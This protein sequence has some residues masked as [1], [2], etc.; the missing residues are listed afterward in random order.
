MKK[1]LLRQLLKMSGFAVGSIIV[2]CLCFTVLF[3]SDINAQKVSIEDIYVKMEGGNK[4]L[5]VLFDEI[6]N[7]TDFYFNFDEKTLKNLQAVQITS[8]V[9]SLKEVLI[10][11]AYQANLSFKR[12]NDNIYVIKNKKKTPT[13]RKNLVFE[14]QQTKVTGKVTSVEDGEPLPG[15]SIII[16]GTSTGAVTD[17]DGNYSLNVDNNSILQFSYI[18]FATQEVE[19]SNQTIINVVMEYDLEQLKEVVV[20]GYGSQKKEDLTG[21]VSSADLK[22]FENAPNVNIAQSLQGTIPGLNVGQVSQAGTTPN[23]SIRGRTSLGGNN[24]VL[25]VVDGIIYTGSITAI[26]PDDIASIDV[27]KDASS[28][29]VYGAQGANGVMLITTKKGRRDRKPTISYT[30]SYTTQNPSSDY[31]PLNREGYLEKVR[32]QYYDEAFLA[33]N[34]TEPNPDFNLA[35]Y[36]DGSMVDENGNILDNDFSWWD[37]ATNTGYIMDHQ[38][39]ISGG[40]E[41]SSYLLSAG[42]TKQKGFII[43][44]LYE[45]KSIRANVDSDVKN[46][47]TI[48]M[49]SFASFGD[50]S[51]AEPQL[52]NITRFSP[53]LTPYDENG[54]MIPFPTNTIEPNPFLTYDVTDL[55]NQNYIFGNFYSEIKFPFLEGLSYRINFGN[56]YRW[57]KYYYASEYSAGQTGRASKDNQFR[58]DYTL[59]NILTYK[60]TINNKHNITATLLYGATERNF[61]RTYASVE[62]FSSLTLGYNSLQ[63]ATNQFATS[64]AWSEALNYQMIRLNYV[65]SEKYLATVTV[66]RDGFSGFAANK[67]WGVFPSAA[68]GWVV[69][70]EKLFNVDFIDFLKLRAGYGSIGNLTSRYFSLSRISRSSAYVFGDGGSPLFGQQVSSLS[71]NDLEWESTTGINFGLDFRLFSDR[72]SGSFEY[73]NTETENQLFKRSIPSITGVNSI[74]VNLGNIKNKG[75]ELSLTSINVQKSDFLWETTLNFSR[76]ANEIVSLTGEDLDGDGVED[77]IIADGRFIGESIGTLY[78]YE[79]GPMY[80]LDDEIPAGYYPGT[81]SVI[82]QNGDGEITPDDRKIIG[83]REPAYRI[84]MLNSFSYKNFTLTV[85]LNSIQGGKNGYLQ[86]NNPSMTRTDNDIRNNYYQQIDF[87]SPSNPDG[88][89]ARSIQNPTLRPGLYQDRS[90]VRLQDI[91]LSYNFS[92]ELLDKT[93]LSGLSLFVSGKNLATW[94]KWEGWDPEGSNPDPEYA[95]GLSAGSRPIMKGYSFGL[96][97]KF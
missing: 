86:N 95:Q 50:Y 23:I 27:L 3:A 82:D 1:K 46:W 21:A 51:G 35:D 28:A 91:S 7:K 9:K 26:N 96:N 73:Y 45:R 6:E 12:V 31:R 32:N 36:V 62:G 58:Y 40:S 65:L 8:S 20:I 66:R 61:D 69:S 30:T 25:I 47:W 39:S 37:A 63:Q 85:F 5:K 18:G 53:L 49:Q 22:S 17:V 75:V 60:K 92:G 77:D 13:S 24:S 79:A 56:T 87:W 88:K 57:D 81:Y 80:Q 72:L 94:T 76:N 33:P 64:S 84:S 4:E 2:Q 52:S 16:K 89:Y 43:N 34:Y 70:N 90:F 67:K 29:A 74:N 97:V 59:D 19:V 38:I 10:D 55:N 54:D 14:I 71:N 48:G 93:G 41:S 15:V 83:R 78:G 42:Y 44:D 11:I 68:L